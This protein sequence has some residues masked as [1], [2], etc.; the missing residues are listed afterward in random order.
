MA[1]SA[2]LGTLPLKISCLKGGY[3]HKKDKKYYA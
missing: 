1:L 3:Q 2:Q